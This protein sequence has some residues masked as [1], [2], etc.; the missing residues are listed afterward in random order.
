MLVVLGGGDGTDTLVGGVGADV[1][2]GGA[3]NDGLYGD[4]VYGG[5]GGNDSLD[6]G[7]GNDYL[8]GGFGSDTY[9]MARGY[10]AERVQDNDT[11][12]GSTDVMQF[13]SGVAADQLWFRKVGNDLEVS[14]IGTTDKATVQNWYLGS[15]Y[16]IEQFKTSDGKILLD[17]K[18]QDL[19]SAMA[20]FAP[21]AIGQTTLP[22]NYQTTLL[23]VIAADWG[24]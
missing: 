5:A 20:S 22:A 3:G 2:T 13:A 18:V 7:A 10:G 9:V 6:G 15:Q 1:L 11:T 16:H 17:S 8:V 14:I 23:P 4:G 19:V 24:P 21:P 12:V